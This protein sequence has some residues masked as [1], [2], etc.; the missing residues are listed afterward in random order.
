MFRVI[1]FIF[2]LFKKYFH[3]STL[4]INSKISLKLTYNVGK[5]KNY[6]IAKKLQKLQNCH[7]KFITNSYLHQKD[8]EL[9]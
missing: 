7:K 3:R 6:N 8:L 2:Y 5:N 9:I 4:I 1:N